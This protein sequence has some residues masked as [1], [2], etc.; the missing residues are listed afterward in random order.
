MRF[1]KAND[2]SAIHYRTLGESGPPVVLIQGLTLSGR[3][4]FDIPERLAKAGY[5]VFW[6]DNRGTGKSDAI[7]SRFLTMATLA[8][9]VVAMLD[10]ENIGEATLVGISMGGMIA[11]HVAL[12]HRERVTG[13][14]LMATTCGLPHGVLPKLS[15]LAALF[16]L[17]FRRGTPRAAE[18]SANLL[19]PKRDHHRFAE[20][21]GKWPEAFLADPQRRAT[22]F[23]Q[24]GAVLTHSTGAKLGKLDLPVVVIT[25]DEDALVP[26]RNSKTIARLIP[27]AE[28]EVLA[29]VGHS[30]PSLDPD[31]VERALARLVRKPSRATSATTAS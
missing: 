3:F 11:Q 13:L 29:G 19:L 27:N 10:Q 22:F 20:L 30:I 28:L 1:T 6:L 9:D 7:K 18:L 25:G 4:W 15:T 5:R 17:P 14:V 2:G 21:F 12:R 26:P 31:V 24:I 8:D 16:E 23:Y